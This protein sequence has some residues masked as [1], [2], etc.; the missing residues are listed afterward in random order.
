MML[1]IALSAGSVELVL[2]VIQALAET[3]TQLHALP[4]SSQLCFDNLVA[5]NNDYGLIIPTDKVCV[6]R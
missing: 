6:C 2:L 3:D 4:A 5:M 1:S